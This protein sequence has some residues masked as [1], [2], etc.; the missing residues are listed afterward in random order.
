MMKI[1]MKNRTP[2]DMETREVSRGHHDYPNQ[3]IRCFEN[4]SPLIITMQGNISIFR[5]DKLAL[6]CSVKCPGKV[7]ITLYDYMQAL[8]EQGQT[9][10]SGFHSPLEKECLRIL[11]RGRQPVIICPARAIQNM[12]LPEDWK[13]PLQEGQL[14]LISPFKGNQRRVT[15]DHAQQRNEFVAALADRIL[16]PYSFPGGRTE[17]LL[18]KISRWNKPILT[19]I[20]ST[21]QFAR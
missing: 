20:G 5:N 15:I 3:L 10:I 7:I 12:R 18:E 11:L 16:I 1:T 9:V 6:F 19:D 2:A 13:K 21:M 8:C 17:K 4:R 14:L